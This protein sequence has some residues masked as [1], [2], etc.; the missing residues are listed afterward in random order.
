MDDIPWYVWCI[1]AF[2]LSIIFF[3]GFVYM[4]IDMIKDFKD[5]KCNR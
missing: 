1:I 3:G 2:S 4:T 5:R